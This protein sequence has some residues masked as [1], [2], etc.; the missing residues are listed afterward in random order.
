[1]QSAFSTIQFSDGAPRRVPQHEISLP[2]ENPESGLVALHDFRCHRSGV[3]RGG[4]SMHR[5]PRCREMEAPQ[6]PLSTLNAALDTSQWSG[7]LA[8]STQSKPTLVCHCP[9]L[10]TVQQVD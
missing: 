5:S 9:V 10:R 7:M 3:Y 6:A 8:S 4:W 2:P 1:M